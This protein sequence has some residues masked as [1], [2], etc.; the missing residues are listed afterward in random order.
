MHINFRQIISFFALSALVGGTGCSKDNTSSNNSDQNAYL[1]TRDKANNRVMEVV[2]ESGKPLQARILIG[3]KVGF[4]FAN[5]L[6]DTKTNGIM[7]IPSAWTTPQPVTIDVPDYVRLTLLNQTPGK[8][9][10]VLRKK[11]QPTDFELNGTS[12]GFQTKD[13]DDRVDAGLLLGSIKKADILAFSISSLISPKTDQLSIIG[14]DFD[15]PSNITIPPQKE[16]Y[17]LTVNLNKPN[18]RAYFSNGGN[19]TVFLA[20][21]QGPFKKIADGAKN[22]NPIYD[23]VN[24]VNITGGS[25]KQVNLNGPKTTLN[26]NV[27]EMTFTNKL[28]YRAPQFDSSQVVLTASVAELPEGFLP[29]DVKSAKAG[30]SLSLNAFTQYPTQMR[31]L[32]VLKNKNEFSLKNPGADRFSAALQNATASANVDL[33]P[34][35]ADPQVVNPQV[36]QFTPPSAKNLNPLASSVVISEVTSSEGESEDARNST[37]VWEIR[38][39]SW[40]NQVALPDFPEK[41][42]RAQGKV[43]MSYLA[44][45]NN[46]QAQSWD[47]I[48]QATTHVTHSSKSY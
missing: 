2:D 13:F 37:P 45:S 15:L 33:L 14:F 24:L 5:N 3:D 16:S 35:L 26:M 46:V 25:I 36:F 12:S 40:I 44:S 23:L 10:V 32:T 28:S 39:T 43:E 21:A 41:N 29:A 31:F 27:A 7:D 1:V 38:A 6:I 42:F 17:F 11:I 22:K 8:M 19:K 20:R 30:E 9:K 34:L 4:P 18:Y 48:I 47:E